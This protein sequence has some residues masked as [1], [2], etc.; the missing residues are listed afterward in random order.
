VGLENNWE[1]PVKKALALLLL[2]V[3][4]GRA[5]ADPV[6]H[7]NETALSAAFAGNLDN[8]AFGCNDA[9]HESRMMAMMHV[10]IHDALNAI[11]RR[12]QPYAFDGHAPDAS[13]DAAVAAAA[14]DVL[15]AIY[16]GCRGRSA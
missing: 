13:P 4:P 2:L 1:D 7:W 12:Y 15:V 14:H 11:D 5:A 9:L 16:L 3:W 10:A 8:L 6:I